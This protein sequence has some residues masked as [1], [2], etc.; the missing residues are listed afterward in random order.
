MEFKKIE[1][2]CKKQTELLAFFNNFLVGFLL[3]MKHL[4]NISGMLSILFAPTKLR[5]PMISYL[6]NNKGNLM[7]NEEEIVE[8]FN[9]FCLN[10]FENIIGSAPTLLNDSSKP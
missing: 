2:L 1:R 7:Q 6:L 3:K 10:T 5:I 4:I 8:R 9:T